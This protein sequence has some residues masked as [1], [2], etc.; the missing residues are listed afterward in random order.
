MHSGNLILQSIKIRWEVSTTPQ[1]AS[2]YYYLSCTHLYDVYTTNF[3]S[4]TR[5]PSLLKNQWEP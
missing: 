3:I 2:L 1:H 4:A 5:G